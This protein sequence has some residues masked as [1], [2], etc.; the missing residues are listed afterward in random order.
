M[1]RIVFFCVFSVLLCVGFA[2]TSGKPIHSKSVTTDDLQVLED[3]VTSLNLKL[4]QLTFLA[5]TYETYLIA[6]END[7]IT[8]A[9]SIRLLTDSVNKLNNRPLMTKQQYLDLY[10]YERLL[11]Y[12]NICKSRPVNWKYYKGWS[13]RVFEGD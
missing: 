4:D 6:Y 9:D 3:S 10:K 11:K 5:A 12:Y 1:K 2:C 7:C 8:K 13:T